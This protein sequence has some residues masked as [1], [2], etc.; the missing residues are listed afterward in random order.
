MPQSFAFH[1][2]CLNINKRMVYALRVNVTEIQL[3]I[4]PIITNLFHAP[5][6]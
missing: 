5:V 6:K 3:Q 4:L 2:I 1:Q